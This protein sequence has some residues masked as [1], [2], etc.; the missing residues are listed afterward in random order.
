MHGD[1]FPIEVEFKYAGVLSNKTFLNGIVQI[2]IWAS[3]YDY[4]PTHSY[5]KLL[6][7]SQYKG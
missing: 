3:V 4:E 2:V 1:S 7:I 5:E 6:A